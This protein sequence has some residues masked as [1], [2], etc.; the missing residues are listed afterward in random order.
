[1]QRSTA[2]TKQPIITKVPLLCTKL[3]FGGYATVWL[4]QQT[5]NTY[6]ESRKFV[7]VKITTA[8]S[9]DDTEREAAMLKQV[10]SPNVLTL[11]DYLRLQGP[12][13]C[14]SVL[15][16]EVLVPAQCFL[17]VEL[18][19]KRTP[20]W[21][22]S[23]ARGLAQGLANIHAAGLVM[24][25]FILEILFCVPQINQRDQRDVMQDLK[26][27]GS[28]HCLPSFSRTSNLMS[29]LAYLI[30]DFGNAHKAGELTRKFQC[31]STVCAP[32]LAFEVVVERTENPFIESPVDVW[33]L[34]A[35]Y[36]L[37]TTSDLFYYLSMIERLESTMVQLNGYIPV[38]WQE[39]WS[40]LSNP[41]EVS[42]SHA[43]VFWEKWHAELRLGCLDH[44][45]T[46]ALVRSLRKILVLDPEARPTAAEM[47]EDRG[48]L[49]RHR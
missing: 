42:A 34:G 49:V 1:M 4:A 20:A 8:E 25:L 7:A 28:K 23:V 13:G 40:G 2:H 47:L 11:L 29:L 3:G 38:S 33:T 31:A 26:L 39:W 45:D 24:G 18:E 6:L 48:L 32:V 5:D 41:P 43:D 9:S 17:A 19:P 44:A 10:N 30:L 27:W 22:K 12:N 14:H 35:I 16:T 37:I 36:E 21:C 15:V 46:A